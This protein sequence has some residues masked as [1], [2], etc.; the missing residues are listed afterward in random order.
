[1]KNHRP[2]HGLDFRSP[3]GRL[4][5]TDA[6]IYMLGTGWDKCTLMHLAEYAFNRMQKEQGRE[7]DT[8]SCYAS[9]WRGPLIWEDA[10][11]Y[12]D[13]FNRLGDAFVRSYPNDIRVMFPP[14]I[15]E[16][17]GRH[18]KPV[19][20]EYRKRLHIVRAAKLIPF[21]IDRYPLLR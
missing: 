13:L 21:C 5:E 12:P 15:Q 2:E 18:T 1:M 20:E 14:R 17:F 11:F 7:T 19:P 6:L 4:F 9:T 10:A 8:V 16:P 3:S